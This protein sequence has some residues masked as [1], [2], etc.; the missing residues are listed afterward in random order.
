MNQKGTFIDFIDDRPVF[1]KDY[2]D[3]KGNKSIVNRNKKYNMKYYVYSSET[4]NT[5]LRSDAE[6]LTILDIIKTADEKMVF[7]VDSNNKISFI[8]TKQKNIS[9]E[10]IIDKVEKT[11]LFKNAIFPLF[12]YFIFFG[13][14]RFRNYS[15]DEAQLSLGY[16]KTIN[17][18]LRFFFPAKLRK[19]FSMNTGMFS[20]LIHAYVVFI[21]M[22]AIYQQYVNTS[23][24]NT[25]VY[26]R[27]KQPDID[28]I[29]NMKSRTADKYNKRHYLFNT[30]SYRLRNCNVELFIR[31][32]VTGQYVIVL[33][34]VL[35]RFIK[36]KEMC[37][38]F[39]SLL[40][41]NRDRYDIYFEKFSAGASESA[42][43]IFKY[44]YQKNGSC[45]YILDKEHPE[46][47]NLK[48]QYGS[49]LV[50]K[51]S[52]L[53]FYYIFLARSFISSDLVSHLQRRLYDNDGLIKRK[54]LENDKKIFLQHGVCLATNVFERGYF[55]RKVPIAPDYV[56]VNSKYERNLFVKNT[57]YNKENLM[58]TGLPNL[59]LYVKEQENTKDEITF[60]LTWR[61]WDLTG[62]I[63]NGSYLSRYFSFMESIKEQEFYHDKQVNIILHPKSKMILKEQFPEIYAKYQHFFYESDIKE[64]L[65][66]S[67]VL[68]SDYSSVVFYA[69]AGGSNIVFYWEDKER[70][71]KEYGA[72]NILQKDIAFGD[73]AERFNDL[74]SLIS[75]NYSKPQSTANLSQYSKLIECKS[76]Q[77]TKAT[78]DYIQ[79]NILGHNQNSE[80][81]K[82]SSLKEVLD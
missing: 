27:L 50:E 40:S 21:P 63:E 73:I 33:T 2:C 71:E 54:V 47:E 3:F 13:V 44:A 28:F 51:N 72:P 26:I 34:S 59:D 12:F 55:N 52:F 17:Y 19:K 70:A 18:K 46:F 22:R 64:A 42:F 79:R 58:L 25:P 36:W 68:I 14:M 60:M 78:Y 69:F 43:E 80:T 8:R 57:N 37:A 4:G 9:I 75:E 76:G 62:E 24:I 82:R 38:Y 23:D 32:S 11:P 56:L 31:K 67:K 6:P 20:L 1:A 5:I 49:S 65:L 29:Y 45:V 7:Y 74:H 81:D 30:R 10:K 15:F 53:A 48:K 61:P 39:T 66:R 16:D 35:R 77:N 41:S